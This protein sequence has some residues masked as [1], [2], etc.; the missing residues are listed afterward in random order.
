MR[1]A[2]D[3]QCAA[4]SVRTETPVVLGDIIGTIGRL[5]TPRNS[6]CPGLLSGFCSA[7]RG[8]LDLIEQRCHP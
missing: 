8:Q 7:Q 3:T 2:D 1:G 4:L 6:P 5:S